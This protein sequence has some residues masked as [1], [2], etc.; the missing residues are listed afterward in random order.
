MQSL[1]MPSQL[2]AAE[3]S[4]YIPHS[5]P[6]VLLDRVVRWDSNSILCTTGSH[7][8]PNNPLRVGGH[9]S[10]TQTIEYT[11]QAVSLHSALK[12]ITTLTPLEG[13]SEL[14]GI[15]TAYLAVIRDFELVEVNLEEFKDEL[16]EVS[17][18]IYLTGPRMLQYNVMSRIGAL[19][20]SKGLI[21]LVVQ[22]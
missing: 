6:M 19:V 9:L 14:K 20:V 10:S 18:H 12:T 17:A 21:S 22:G 3:L 13:I 5:G 2:D 7:R 1:D 15:E 16:L 11:A 8:N 4:A